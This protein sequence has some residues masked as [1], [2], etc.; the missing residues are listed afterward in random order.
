MSIKDELELMN[1]YYLDGNTQSVKVRCEYLEKLKTNLHNYEEE[2][3]DALYRDLRKSKQE[4]YMCE[5]VP[6]LTEI[7][8]MLKNVDRLS[9][10][11]P[12]K[13]DLIVK[14][15]SS[16]RYAKPKGV[17]LIIA[18]WNY[19]INLTLVPLVDALA[20]GNVVALKPSELSPNTSAVLAKV[21][22]NTFPK[23]YVSVFEGDKDV[24]DELMEYPFDHILYTGGE[25][26]AKIIAAKAAEHLIP[27]TLE[28][29]G[30]SP[31][32]IDENCNLKEASKRIVF[33]KCL[34]A[35]QTCIAPDYILVPESVKDEFV[36][37]LCEE[38]THQYDSDPLNCEYY[39]KIINERH[40]NRLIHLMDN[41]HIVY[42]GNYDEEQL[43]IMPTIIDNVRGDEPIMQEEIFG[44]LLP[45]LTY[46]K[47]EE[48]LNF[49][50]KRPHPLAL[51]AFSDDKV[52]KEQILS[53]LTFGGATFN[54][55]IMHNTNINLPFG[56]IGPSGMGAYHGEA[57]FN[58]FTH[59]ES[60]V[61][62]G[63]LTN[64]FHFAPFSDG[65]YKL[66]RK[67][68]K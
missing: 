3:L 18:P 30:K 61:E 45:I 50:R 8:Y 41:T 7:D 4:A 36:K 64:P 58:T 17:V 59:H 51:Y 44:P 68:I 10:A 47:F 39:P 67:A 31:V 33:G 65:K 15:S 16:Y 57:G 12:V 54:D 52:K 14:P 35:G 21:I 40:F 53:T 26:V 38:I 22:G 2:I 42:G 19:P 11:H 60:I 9:G 63:K 13:G 34:N 25:R 48:T 5:F 1:Q 24:V 49:V 37:N 66:I 55:T 28:L 20:A 23:S 27:L 56:G 46:T 6:L 29:G 43:I 32:I 62:G